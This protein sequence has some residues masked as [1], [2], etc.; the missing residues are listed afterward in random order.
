[1][2]PAAPGCPASQQVFRPCRAQQGARAPLAR[3]RP[4][5]GEEANENR[6]AWLQD[7]LPPD[8]NTDNCVSA[9]FRVSLVLRARSAPRAPLACRCVS[10]RGARI[11]EGRAAPWVVLGEWGDGPQSYREVMGPPGVGPPPRWPWCPAPR[12]DLLVNSHPRSKQWKQGSGVTGLWFQAGEEKG[13]ASVSGHCRACG[14]SMVGTLG[15]AKT[16][17]GPPPSPSA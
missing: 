17:A 8:P 11:W 15:A 2:C 14:Q 6:G 5:L 3:G 4:V 9:P 13:A 12:V 16:V 1:M 7:R 10:G